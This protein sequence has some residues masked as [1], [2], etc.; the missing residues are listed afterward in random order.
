[1][2]TLIDDKLTPLTVDELIAGMLG[3]YI[4][5]MGDDARPS[6]GQLA[7]LV[8]QACL[9]TGN[10]KHVHC[11]NLGNVKASK[12]WDGLVCQ[13]KCNEVINGKVEWFS[14]PHPQTHFRAFLSAADG[15]AEFVGFLANRERYRRAWDRACAG[16]A[17]GFVLALGAAG[18]FTANVETYRRAVQSIANR[19]ELACARALA[20]DAHEFTAMDLEELDGL[21]GIT[22]R[23][24][25]LGRYEHSEDRMVA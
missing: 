5:N 18:Y 2:A 13:Y 17:S 10:G 3:G 22:L 20:A 14:P 24:S 1:M 19:V 8:A 21:V 9:E 11:W 25:T 6:A 12:D 15:C 16:D 23:E 7:C 4:H